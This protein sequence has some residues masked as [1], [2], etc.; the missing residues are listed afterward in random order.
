MNKRTILTVIITIMCIMNLFV[1][2]IPDGDSYFELFIRGFFSDDLGTGWKILFVAP[3]SILAILT[4]LHILEPQS[5][6]I[7][8]NHLSWAGILG[9]GLY[10]VIYLVVYAVISASIG[11]EDAIRGYATGE[12]YDSGNPDYSSAGWGSLFYP[13]LFLSYVLVHRIMH[14]NKPETDPGYRS[15]N[16][17]K[18][19]GPPPKQ[20]D[21]NEY[22]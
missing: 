6:G 17:R 12:S 2:F 15:I 19:S 22:V 9:F 7:T 4:L 16:K 3:T 14:Y 21:T 20:D 8:R 10:V 11:L 13:I 1:G 18:S 5:S